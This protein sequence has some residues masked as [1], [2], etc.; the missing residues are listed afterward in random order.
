MRI[1]SAAAALLVGML[2]RH[3]LAFTAPSRDQ[4]ATSALHGRL[5]NRLSVTSSAASAAESDTLLPDEADNDKNVVLEWKEI[6]KLPYRKL[7]KRLMARNLDTLGT[8]AVLQARLHEAYGGECIIEGDKAIGICA[9][10]QVAAVRL[11]ATAL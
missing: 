2:A 10:D 11:H 3:S 4:P 8:T 5:V 6:S 9:D 1:S 7:Q